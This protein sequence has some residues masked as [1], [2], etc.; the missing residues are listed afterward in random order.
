MAKAL[1]VTF[2]DSVD[3]K[4]HNNPYD[5]SVVNGKE[6]SL[7]ER[8]RRLGEFAGASLRSHAPNAEQFGAKFA[9]VGAEEG[10]LVVVN[11]TQ[12]MQEFCNNALT[13]TR[14]AKVYD[15]SEQDAEHYAEIA[16][17]QEQ[18]REAAKVKPEDS[19]KGIVFGQDTFYGDQTVSVTV[20][21]L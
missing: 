12:S 18:E 16:D 1:I 3:R 10:A 20:T 21:P 8:G 6:I 7:T 2:L 14:S 11:P 15:I 13:F 17:A 9:N 4:T 19:N 5:P